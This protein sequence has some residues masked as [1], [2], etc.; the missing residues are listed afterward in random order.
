[1]NS[2]V[3]IAT[4]RIMDRTLIHE[5][6][7]GSYKSGCDSKVLS[8]YQ[9]NAPK[10]NWL[11][12]EKEAATRLSKRKVTKD[13]SSSDSIQQALCTKLLTFTCFRVFQIKTKSITIL[14]LVLIHIIIVFIPKQHMLSSRDYIVPANLVYTG[15]MVTAS[16]CFLILYITLDK[17]EFVYVG[18]SYII[19]G[20]I[21][22]LRAAH[23]KEEF[24]G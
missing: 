23:G 3:Y 5:T 15:L 11:W 14:I 12:W 6:L 7:C 2:R 18:S 1:M 20:T 13:R 8:L 19:M 4:L 9:Q 24:R 17:F 21:S 16:F 22:S 10:H